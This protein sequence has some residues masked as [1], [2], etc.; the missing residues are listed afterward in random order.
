MFVMSAMDDIL[1]AYSIAFVLVPKE[2]NK[3]WVINGRVNVLGI[4]EMD[5]IKNAGSYFERE[6]EIRQARGR[7]IDQNFKG[8]NV[9]V[10]SVQKIPFSLSH[11]TSDERVIPAFSY[12]GRGILG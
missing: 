2:G 11:L 5:A 3:K 9:N 10:R 1:N 4:D 6:V 7:T 8:Y 12:I